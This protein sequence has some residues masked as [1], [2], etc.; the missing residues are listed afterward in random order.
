[1]ELLFDELSRALIIAALM[2]A[3]P[4]LVA[5]AVGTFVA[6]LQAASQLQEQTLTFV[7]KLAAV[8]GT[9]VVLSSWM[10]ELLCELLRTALAGAPNS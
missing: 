2:A 9:L 5:M 6:V 10:G 7:P 3:A 4:L 8:S 1:M